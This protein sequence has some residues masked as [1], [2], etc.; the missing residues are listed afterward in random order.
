MAKGSKPVKCVIKLNTRNLFR[1]LDVVTNALDALG[2]NLR[3]DS[4]NQFRAGGRGWQQRIP[5]VENGAFIIETS[6][7]LPVLLVDM[8]RVR[9]KI[10]EEAAATQINLR[11]ANSMRQVAINNTP[12]LTGRAQASITATADYETVTLQ[13]GGANVPYFGWI[14]FGGT[15]VQPKRNRRIERPFIAKTGRIIYY[16]CK[17]NGKA[18]QRARYAQI[19][20]EFATIKLLNVDRGNYLRVESITKMPTVIDANRK[21]AGTGYTVKPPRRTTVPQRQHIHQ[22]QRLPV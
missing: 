6:T 10:E 1:A 8:E 3:S 11:F 15:I 18:M 16:A 19:L 2:V 13:G 14:D 5:L 7:D 17:D 22:Q 21:P 4:D 12:V 20:E 9:Q